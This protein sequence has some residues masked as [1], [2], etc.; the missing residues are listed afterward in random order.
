MAV[1]DEGEVST[2]IGLLL[3]AQKSMIIIH[4]RVP[5]EFP[6]NIQ[7]P[8]L[9]TATGGKIEGAN[10]EAKGEVWRGGGSR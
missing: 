3:N 8:L 5:V 4:F 9:P 1:V 10:G 6:P 2:S 7:Q